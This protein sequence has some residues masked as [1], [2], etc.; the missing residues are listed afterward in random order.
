[1]GSEEKNPWD[2]GRRFGGS[3]PEGCEVLIAT[4]QGAIVVRVFKKHRKERVKVQL[5][6]WKDAEGKIQGMRSHLYEGPIDV[7]PR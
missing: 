3:D 2:R 6:P 1:M 4:E 5:M 7:M